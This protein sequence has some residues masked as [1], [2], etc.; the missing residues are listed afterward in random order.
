[1]VPFGSDSRFFVKG[2]VDVASMV[3]SV[4]RRPIVSIERKPQFNSLGQV[5]IRDEVATKGDQVRIPGF[6]NGRCALGIKTSSRDDRP[7]KDSTQPCRRNRL[8]MR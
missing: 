5:G 8:P 1:M 2:I 6:H 3:A 4:E 7:R